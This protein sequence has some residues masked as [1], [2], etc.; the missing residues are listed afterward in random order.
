MKHFSPFAALALIL[1]AVP[2]A[3][4]AAPGVV[5]IPDASVYS[6]VLAV[7]DVHGMRPAL[8]ALLKGAGVIGD[9]GRWA[10]GNTL[11]IV[12]GDSIDKGPQSL[13][14]LDE[15]IDLQ[16]QAA[17][18]GGRVVHLLGNHEAEFL[19][20]PGHSRKAA[21]LYAELQARGIPVGDLT[22][23]A[24]RYGRFL[25]S[26]PLAARVGR[27]LFCHAGLYPGPNWASFKSAASAA[28]GSGAYGDDLLQADDSILEAKD[29]WKDPSA[30]AALEA[31]LT[32]DGMY[33]LVQGHQ[34]KA[35]GFP[36][37][38]GALDGGRLVKIDGGMAPEAGSHPGG[39]LR[40]SNPSQ[41]NAAAP[42]DLQAVGPD[43][44]ASPVPAR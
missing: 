37:R 16:P 23:P 36:N 31:K 38:I 43:G 34:P 18:A 9:D 44:S 17:A 27:W 33:G 20:S 29:W 8:D 11:L 21:E 30:R 24:K 39:M 28:L 10:A 22:D 12:V 7:S 42:A 26:E 2:W 5:E 32:A 6:Q 1:V 4:A 25:L 40:F 13:E 14:V 19:A 35:Y 3:R 15:W 41:M